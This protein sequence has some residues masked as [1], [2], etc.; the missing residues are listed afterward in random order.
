MTAINAASR[1]KTLLSDATAGRN[2]T[3]LLALTT[4]MYILPGPAPPICS[5][6]YF[7][8]AKQI[9]EEGRFPRRPTNPDPTSQRDT[10]VLFQH[11]KLDWTCLMIFFVVSLSTGFVGGPFSLLPCFSLSVFSSCADL[12]RLLAGQQGLSNFLIIL[13]VLGM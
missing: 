9:Y 10:N 8:V 7:L 1:G 13:L 12:V 5:C 4:Y 6:L 11:L 3:N 2:R